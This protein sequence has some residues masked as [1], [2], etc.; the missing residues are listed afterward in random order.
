MRSF[1]VL[2]SKNNSYLT[3][4]NNR[5]IHL[6]L[7]LSCIFRITELDKS[8]ATRLPR[9]IILRKVD[10]LHRTK[11]LKW[12][13]EI[14]RPGIE[15][16]I[17]EKEARRSRRTAVSVRAAVAR[18][19]VVAVAPTGTRWGSAAAAGAVAAASAPVPRH[20]P[21]IGHLSVRR[22]SLRNPNPKGVGFCGVFPKFWREK[23]KRS[24]F[25]ASF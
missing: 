9:V 24:P 19:V 14:F 7:S 22:F 4:S 23:K 8:K 10:I 12:Y 18:V 13:P 16:E 3:S 21:P 25:L 20:G 1:S 17:A 5:M 6:L 15:R 11:P 2:L